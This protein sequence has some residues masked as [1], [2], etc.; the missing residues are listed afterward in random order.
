[1]NLVHELNEAVP[2]IA[3]TG[4]RLSG[5]L[6]CIDSTI[7]I[8]HFPLF[9]LYIPPVFVSAVCL[10]KLDRIARWHGPDIRKSWDRWEWWESRFR[11]ILLDRPSRWTGVGM[12]VKGQF[13]FIGR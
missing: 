10:I 11:L 8:P 13:Q 1:M 7:Q 9:P 12:M 3:P 4:Y 6:Q 5:T 2:T